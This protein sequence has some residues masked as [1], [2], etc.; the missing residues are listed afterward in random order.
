MKNEL[1]QIKQNNYNNKK[2]NIIEKIFSKPEKASQVIL[3]FGTTL[4]IIYQMI[5]ILYCMPYFYS[6]KIELMFYRKSIFELYIGAFY[7]IIILIFFFTYINNFYNE[8]DETTYTKKTLKKYIKF[9]LCLLVLNYL[10]S[11]DTFI[12]HYLNYIDFFKPA[13]SCVFS[14]ALII[15]YKKK[16]GE[17][18]LD[19]WC[20]LCNLPI[21]L[22]IIAISVILILG[23]ANSNIKKDYEIITNVDNSNEVILYKTAEYY[24]IADCSIN[25]NNLTV[26]TDTKRKIDNND[27]QS[28]YKKFKSVNKENKKRD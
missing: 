5:D 28:E 11:I 12:Y 15:Y 26:Y 13:L 27:I 24:I 2:L 21:G 16:I 22:I 10:F 20:M 7:S 1:Q 14:Y 25:N 4:F 6:W 19:F 17:M 18:I 3:F 8:I 23:F 9:F